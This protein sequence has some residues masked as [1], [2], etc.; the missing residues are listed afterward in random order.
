[1]KTSKNSVSL[2]GKAGN[3]PKITPFENGKVARV[4]IAVND[5]Y[6]N[7]AGETA[8][9]TMWFT[10]VFWNEK[11]DLADKIK[12]GTGFSVEGK[13]AS[14]KFNGKNGKPTAQKLLLK[15]LKSSPAK[16]S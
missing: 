5:S 6:L 2:E 7:R 12:K 9:R 15:M 1:M 8:S 4:S 3:D 11:A 16:V 10:I 14:Q 13:L